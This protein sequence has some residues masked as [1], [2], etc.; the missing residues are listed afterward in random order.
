M[1]QVLPSRSDGVK[2]VLLYLVADIEWARLM[3]DVD[4]RKSILA[5]LESHHGRRRAQNISQQVTLQVLHTSLKKIQQDLND[6]SALNLRS[7]KSPTGSSLQSPHTFDS[8]V[9][10]TAVSVAISV[11]DSITSQLQGLPRLLLLAFAHS[12]LIVLSDTAE[13]KLSVVYRV[14]VDFIRENFDEPSCASLRDIVIRMIKKVVSRIC[15]KERSVAKAL[16]LEFMETYPPKE[17]HESI[18]KLLDDISNKITPLRHLFRST[19]RYSNERTNGGPDFFSD[20]NED[21]A[22]MNK[23]RQNNKNTRK[24]TTAFPAFFSDEEAG[25]DDGKQTDNKRTRYSLQGEGLQPRTLFP[26]GNDHGRKDSFA[27]RSRLSSALMDQEKQPLSRGDSADGDSDCVERTNQAIT[28]HFYPDLKKHAR[29]N[30]PYP[31][32]SSSCSDVLEK[33]NRDSCP[34]RPRLKDPGSSSY[35]SNLQKPRR[36]EARVGR[37]KSESP[38]QNAA[39]SPGSGVE[40]DDLA[41]KKNPRNEGSDDEILGHSLNYDPGTTGSPNDS[42]ENAGVL[43]VNADSESINSETDGDVNDSGSWKKRVRAT[44]RLRKANR[45]LKRNKLIDPLDGSLQD[46]DELTRKSKRRKRRLLDPPASDARDASPIPECS[47]VTKRRRPARAD[48]LEYANDSGE[49][50][51]PEIATVE[52]KSIGGMK[53]A[54]G[55]F[56]VEE[57]D[58]LIEGLRKFGWGSWMMIAKNFGEGKAKHTR[59]GVSL[60]DRARNLHLDPAHYLKPSGR[61]EPRGRRSNLT[62]VRGKDKN[63]EEEA[64][65]VDAEETADG[66][67]EKDLDEEAVDEN[68]EDDVDEEDA[69]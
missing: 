22:G 52:D 55:R 59:S 57:D 20:D 24:A 18:T 36:R 41:L 26:P 8:S 6:S 37:K 23:S 12:S 45:V 14:R 21:S 40:L 64:A 51:D 25:A 38:G 69:S 53:V 30:V 50:S 27:K 29:A 5:L 56:S 34:K 32:S 49:D 65:G 47:P 28:S 60:K 15:A 46:A 31:S 9:I 7:V 63:A 35:H 48:L 62:P 3:W 54:R 16:A 19:N 2:E 1:P 11:L 33:I 66:N 44:K 4:T 67:V 17:L 42:V 43:Q 13:D 58:W 39:D 10:F 61:L 68:A